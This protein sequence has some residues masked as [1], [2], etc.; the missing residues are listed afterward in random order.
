MCAASEDP[1]DGLPDEGPQ[2]G[3]VEPLDIDVKVRGQFRAELDEPETDLSGW[4]GV[5]RLLALTGPAADQV[6]HEV[7]ELP[8]GDP[9]DDAAVVDVSPCRR[10]VRASREQR[11][12]EGRGRCTRQHGAQRQPDSGNTLFGTQRSVDFMCGL[13]QAGFVLTVFKGA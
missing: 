3:H 6:L 2:E 7:V 11:V 5:D 10:A 8:Q 12:S 4:A 13:S 9:A 1:S